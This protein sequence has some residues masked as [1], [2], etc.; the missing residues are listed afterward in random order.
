MNDTQITLPLLT[1]SRLKDAR[2]CQRRHKMH[3]ID[4]YL[5]VEEAQPLRFGSMIHAALEMWWSGE[6]ETRL[7]EALSVIPADA[8]PFEAAMARALVVGYDARWADQNYGVLAVEHE[9][10]VP[11]VNPATGAASRTWQLAGKIDAIAR[12][13]DGR[14]LIVEHKTASQE[15][16]PGSDYLKRLR[17]DSQVSV[18]FEGA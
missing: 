18:Y 11:L 4:G 13:T 7:V 5:P 1:S 16:E 8:D 12:H 15:I 9:F 17:L 10:R 2:A 3:Y 6:P 14:V